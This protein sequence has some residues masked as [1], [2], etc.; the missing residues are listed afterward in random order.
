MDSPLLTDDRDKIQ[1]IRLFVLA[2]GDQPVYAP[3]DITDPDVLSAIE[4]LIAHDKLTPRLVHSQIRIL[5]AVLRTGV[6]NLQRTVGKGMLVVADDGR[7]SAAKKSS[8]EAVA[9]ETAAEVR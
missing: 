8:G 3:I 9:A 4:R 7:L 5:R 6:A 2:K 1:R